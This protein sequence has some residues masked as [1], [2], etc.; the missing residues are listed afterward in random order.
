MKKLLAAMFVALLMVGCGESS[1]PS[2]GVDMTDT[3]PE[4]DSI[5]TA[6][7]LWKLRDRNGVMYLP[8][9]ETPFTGR[10]K[11]FHEN[12]Q[13]K[14]EINFKDGKLDG[15]WTRWY[16]SGQKNAEGNWKDNKLMS[17]KAWK[18]N[19]EKCP[20]TNLQDGNGFLVRYNDDGT[21]KR[22]ETYKDGEIV[23]D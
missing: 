16:E 1:Q 13:K 21:E 2:E 5:E 6:V 4:K 14:V 17:A 7:D 19:G 11:K 9:E 12:G 8:N 18:P 22:R 10:G 15:L 3:D 23:Y 20:V